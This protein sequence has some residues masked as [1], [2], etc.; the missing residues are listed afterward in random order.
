LCLVGGAIVLVPLA[1]I[2]AA[3]ALLLVR[4]RWDFA[5]GAQAALIA[6]PFAVWF[7]YGAG[8]ELFATVGLLCLI[9]ARSAL[10]DRALKREGIDKKRFG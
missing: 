9:G 10:A 8:A 5:R 3:I 4:W 1:C 7:I 2:P 6:A